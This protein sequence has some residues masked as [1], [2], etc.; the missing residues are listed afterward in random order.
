MVRE[1][2]R[3]L[4]GSKTNH[5]NKREFNN[6]LGYPVKVYFNAGLSEN[7]TFGGY[8]FIG[9]Y[10]RIF[11][12]VKLG[13]GTTIGSFNWME[14]EVEIGNYTQVG[15][16]VNIISSN[17]A[18]NT[19]TPYNSNFLFEG[20]MKNITKQ[21]KV[22]IGNNCW[23]GVGVNIVGNIKIGDGVVIGAGALI[24]KDIPSNSVVVGNPQRIIK[25]RLD[26]EIFETLQT[27]KWWN[28]TPDELKEFESL[29]HLDLN[30]N[31]LAVIGELNFKNVPIIN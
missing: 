16:K 22:V 24:N 5:G 28:K 6:Q 12:K 26:T 8:N 13:L 10:T 18:M 31:Q 2:L 15:P 23:I 17:H 11:A 25:N 19:I 29:F 7:I 21:G 1:I 20:K 9:E 3:K 4:L 30:E 27:S 14:G